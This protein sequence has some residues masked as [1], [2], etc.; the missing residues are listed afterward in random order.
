[1]SETLAL[2]A[3]TAHIAAHASESDLDRIVAVVVE[4]RKALATMAA[5]AVTVGA[6]VEIVNLRPADY[7]GKRGTV[8]SI[9]GKHATITFDEQSTKSLRW[10]R[11][12]KINVPEGV[13]QWTPTSLFPLTCLRL[14]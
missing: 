14:V 9:E 3:I 4:R 8:A 10:S 2:S 1:M 5:A 11:S 6:K 12:A 7:K 13:T